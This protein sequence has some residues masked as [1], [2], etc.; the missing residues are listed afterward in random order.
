MRGAWSPDKGAESKFETNALTADSAG[1]GADSQA[2]AA[3][4]ATT[5]RGAKSTGRAAGSGSMAA[6]LA[7]ARFV[8]ETAETGGAA[9]PAESLED[10]IPVT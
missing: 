1:R 7:N 4:C 8:F 6:G 2:R 5:S 3:V 10:T 9:T